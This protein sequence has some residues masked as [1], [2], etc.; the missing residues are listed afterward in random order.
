VAGESDGGAGTGTGAA[1]LDALMLELDVDDEMRWGRNGGLAVKRDAQQAALKH[2]ALPSR[3]WLGLVGCRHN[4][5]TE[6][7]PPHP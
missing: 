2:A 5:C 3:L 4:G 7:R 1:A 6:E